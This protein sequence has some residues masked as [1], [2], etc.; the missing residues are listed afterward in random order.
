MLGFAQ[1]GVFHVKLA[2]W[3]KSLAYDVVQSWSHNSGWAGH[4]WCGVV[5]RRPTCHPLPTNRN[6]RPAWLETSLRR[7]HQLASGVAV[8]L[9]QAELI[10]S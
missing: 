1:P 5:L 7:P 10:R 9:A 3:H 8:S 4:I 6:W 2:A